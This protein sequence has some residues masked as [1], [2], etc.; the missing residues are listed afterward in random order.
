MQQFGM[1]KDVDVLQLEQLNS[2]CGINY[3]NAGTVYNKTTG[4]EHDAFDLH[5]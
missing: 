3:T 5:C 2:I 4:S 1:R